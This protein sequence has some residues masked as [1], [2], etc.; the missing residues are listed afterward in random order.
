MPK[1]R[2]SAQMTRPS[3]SR[4]RPDMPR[5]CTLSRSGSTSL[6][7]SARAA[8]GS[9]RKAR[10]GRVRE[11]IFCMARGT[12]PG[13]SGR[14][15]I[16]E[17]RPTSKASTGLLPEGSHAR[18]A[19]PGDST[20]GLPRASAPARLPAGRDRPRRRA[21][22]RESGEAD[23][24]EAALVAREHDALDDFERDAP[25]GLDVDHAAEGMLRIAGMHG[26]VPPLLVAQG[27][28]DLRDVQRVAFREIAG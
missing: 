10:T 28:L 4:P 21:F 6:A 20:P 17:F 24:R 14:R 9:A 12:P 2:P 22:A 15:T 18:R 3:S 5:N 19:T 7:S 13:F 1:A 26:L 23:V 27:V 25:V 8:N 11:M 16:V